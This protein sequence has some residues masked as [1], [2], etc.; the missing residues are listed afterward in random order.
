MPGNRNKK[1]YIQTILM[2]FLAGG[3]LLVNGH[4]GLVKAGTAGTDEIYKNMEIL[5]EVIRQI[6]K[7]YVEPEDTQKL[8]RGALKGMVQ[9]LDPHSSLL[10]PEAFEELLLHDQGGASRTAHRNERELFRCRD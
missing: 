4:S 10:P 8:I 5:T 3:I 9:S 6:E 1:I 7:N 2:A